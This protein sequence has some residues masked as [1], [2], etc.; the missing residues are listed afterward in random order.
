MQECTIMT[1]NVRGLRD[2]NKRRKVFNY[3][4]EKNFDLVFLQE[5][6]SNAPIERYWR[7]EWG[8]GGCIY[9][10]HGTTESS[11]C[12]ILVRKAF[13]L[14]I[15]DIIRDTEGKY[16][17]MKIQSNES[18]LALVCCYAP[19]IDEPKYFQEL[20]KQLNRLKAD[21]VIIA[22]DFNTVIDPRDIK[23]GKGYTHKRCMSFIN[24]MMRQEKLSDIWR[25]RNPDKFRFTWTKYDKRQPEKSLMERIDYIII[26][27]N[28]QQKVISTD[29][30]SAYLSDHAQPTIYL[31]VNEIDPRGPGRWMINNACCNEEQYVIEI[32]EI[33]EKL[34]QEIDDITVRWEMIKIMTRGHTIQYS[35]QKKKARKNKLIALERKLEEIDCKADT[36]ALFNDSQDKGC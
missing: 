30:L 12:A 13:P 31:R 34:K 20:L 24:E 35:T 33:I 29:I 4:H 26:S 14:Q 23:G 7:A 15:H 36:I 25:V 17:M 21:D 2:S 11:G 9:Y 19:N 1:Y 3:L 32:K 18:T 27:S 8:G 28:L 5:T 10:A 6:H 22:G 16:I